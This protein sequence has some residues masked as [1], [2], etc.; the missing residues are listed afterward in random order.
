MPD[1]HASGV[2]IATFVAGPVPPRLTQL[3]RALPPGETGKPYSF[4]FESDHPGSRF[5]IS[6]D[7]VPFKRNRK[8]YYVFRMV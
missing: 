3:E 4:T 2:A 7:L 5:W 6:G 8:N 1:R